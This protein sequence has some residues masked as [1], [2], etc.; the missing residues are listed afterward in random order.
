MLSQSQ[1]IHKSDQSGVADHLR[2]VTYTSHWKS[3]QKVHG[4]AV[5][6]KLF[7]MTD[8]HNSEQSGVAD[9][10][11]A[12]TYTLHWKSK[13][14][15]HGSAVYAKWFWMTD[16]VIIQFSVYDCL[17]KNRFQEKSRKEL[18]AVIT[19]LNSVE[20]QASCTTSVTCFMK[21]SNL[22]ST[23]ILIFFE[24]TKKINV[25]LFLLNNQSKYTKKTSNNM[26]NHL[27]S[28]RPEFLQILFQSPNWLASEC[29]I[30]FILI[31][32]SI[33]KHACWMRIL[34]QMIQIIKEKTNIT[35]YR[36]SCSPINSGCEGEGV[37]Y[38]WPMDTVIRIFAVISPYT[39]RYGP[40]LCRVSSQ[41]K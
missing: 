2:A 1:I 14:K 13:Q 39:T 25:F 35:Y 31:P 4:S 3:K 41:P 28:I 27:P 9:H 19:M 29:F 30:H 11:R 20:G 32:F 6:A 40:F 38:P 22:L 12:V 36:L 17:F 8:I 34:K 18:K 23:F 10:L 16:M 15:V 37:E 24:N 33:H 7:W 21:E 26:I 5:Y